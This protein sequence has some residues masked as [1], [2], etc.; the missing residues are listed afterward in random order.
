MRIG[1]NGAPVRTNTHTRKGKGKGT[2]HHKEIYIARPPSS[3]PHETPRRVGGDI[4][5]IEWTRSQDGEN[6]AESL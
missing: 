2:L 3:H 1:V 5:A 6:M 4:M